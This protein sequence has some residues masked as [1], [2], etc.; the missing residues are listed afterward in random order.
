M[1]EEKTTKTFPEL[2]V[3]AE[4]LLGYSLKGRTKLETIEALLEALEKTRE[5]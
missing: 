3:R 4:K 5:G 2:K 1:S